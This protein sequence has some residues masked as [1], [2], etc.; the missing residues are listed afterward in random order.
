MHLLFVLTLEPNVEYCNFLQSLVKEA[1]S[2]GHKIDALYLTKSAV[3]LASPHFALGSEQKQLQDKLYRLSIEGE[4]PI[5][6]CGKA[7]RACG[8]PPSN[9]GKGMML[10]VYTE[11]AKC[12]VEADKVVEL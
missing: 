2:R 1:L 9:L 3:A 4:F 6:V 12:I 7:Y 8:L 11:L 5:L 10:S